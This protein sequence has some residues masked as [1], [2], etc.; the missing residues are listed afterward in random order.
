LKPL[1]SNYQS[2]LKEIADTLRPPP[3]NDLP[4]SPPDTAAFF[5]K[6]AFGGKR[7]PNNGLSLKEN[8]RLFV[9][10]DAAEVTDLVLRGLLRVFDR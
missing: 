3:W 4:I 10:T 6:H 7:W 1:T 5:H 8:R 2:L 9:S